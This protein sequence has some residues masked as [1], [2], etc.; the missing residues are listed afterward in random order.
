MHLKKHL[1]KYKT[2]KIEEVR[3]H[4]FLLKHA[5]RHLIER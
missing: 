5:Q 1:N 2:K 3:W 4:V